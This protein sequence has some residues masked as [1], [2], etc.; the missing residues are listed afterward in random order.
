MSSLLCTSKKKLFTH[1]SYEFSLLIYTMHTLRDIS[2][3]NCA[4]FLK[5]L[6]E[7]EGEQKILQN[8]KYAFSAKLLVQEFNVKFPTTQK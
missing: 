6:G 2:N 7:E 1:F 8:K 4:G 3:S 5:I